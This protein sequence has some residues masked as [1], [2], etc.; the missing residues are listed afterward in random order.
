MNTVQKN[1]EPEPSPPPHHRDNTIT[2]ELEQPNTHRTDDTPVDIEEQQWIEDATHSATFNIQYTQVHT[3]IIN[4][5]I[6]YTPFVH[7]L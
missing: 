5:G 1:P 4:S 2:I 6:K 7:K 3:K